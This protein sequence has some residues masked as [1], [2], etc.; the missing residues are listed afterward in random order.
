MDGFVQTYVCFEDA[1]SKDL[2]CNDA[3]ESGCQ[4]G[5]AQPFTPSACN[6]PF[7]SSKLRAKEFSRTSGSAAHKGF[8]FGGN[9]RDLCNVLLD[10]YLFCASK[11]P[12]S[13]PRK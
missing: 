5:A 3:L 4:K 9:A 8:G 6:K 10:S 12:V 13:V 11:G 2:D 1:Y 7:K